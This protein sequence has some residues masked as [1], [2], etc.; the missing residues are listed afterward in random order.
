MKEAFFEKLGT[1]AMALFLALLTWLYLFTQ[2]QDTRSFDAQFD[3]PSLDAKEFAQV[4]YLQG[5]RELSRGSSISIEITGPRADVEALAQ[6]SLRCRPR[7][8]PLS[9][10]E[11]Q[12]TITL[13]L[14]H[15]DF[16][17]PSHFILKTLPTPEITVEYSRY[18]K[19]VVKLV[20]GPEYHIGSPS[21]GFEIRS[22][23]AYPSEV[24]VRI[25]A[26]LHEETTSVPIRK[27]P[28]HARSESF[29]HHDWSIE[30]TP[31]AGGGARIILL[32]RFSV[33]VGIGPAET[34]RK[35]TVPVHL[36]APS[37]HDVELLTKDIEIRLWGP[38]QMLKD[39]PDSAFWVTAIVTED[40]L[41]TP[42]QKNI[43]ALECAILDPRFR[44]VIRVE[45]MPEVKPE[46]R[47][48][49]INVPEKTKTLPQ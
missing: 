30:D 17:L 2:D 48:V 1:W 3:P 24:L 29:W 28:V 19:K 15:K 47:E 32:E 43:T 26:S 42:G 6:R 25:P 38:E 7:F 21:S 13:E 8:D 12:T 41:Q 22:I 45:L 11:N 31:P 23:A 5:E 44:G 16:D 9:L 33:Y 18:K 37:G 40:K 35:T 49:I 10:K 4:R 27:I 36:S 46:N 34:S 14:E 20:T 39:A